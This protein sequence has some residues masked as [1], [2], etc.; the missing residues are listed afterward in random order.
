MIMCNLHQVS[1]AQD[2][3][4]GRRGHRVNMNTLIR[5]TADNDATFLMKNHK[6][7]IL[8]P[9]R[10]TMAYSGIRLKLPIHIEFFSTKKASHIEEN[11]K[12]LL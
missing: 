12:P 1:D 9:L 10:R 8:T 2:L 4:D 3:C 11:R 6:C 5:I 7:S